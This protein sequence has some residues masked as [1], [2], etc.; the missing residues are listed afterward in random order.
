MPV[1]LL[2]GGKDKI[3]NEFC[4][5]TEGDAAYVD[6]LWRAVPVECQP[7]TAILHLPL[8]PHRP[9]VPTLRQV[10]P[11]LVEYA[12]AGLAR[13]SRP[14]AAALGGELPCVLVTAEAPTGE[15]LIPTR[16]EGG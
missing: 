8:M 9:D 13:A 2:T 12:A 1:V 7:T 4:G 6:R 5:Q 3:C 11:A 15:T 10:L 16:S 14:T